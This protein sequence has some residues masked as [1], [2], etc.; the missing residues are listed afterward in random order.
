MRNEQCRENKR[1][2]QTVTRR[3][4]HEDGSKRGQIESRWKKK[5][6]ERKR[7]KESELRICPSALTP[8]NECE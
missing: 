3:R 2:N 6:K 8:S 7:K 4:E 1:E 5:R